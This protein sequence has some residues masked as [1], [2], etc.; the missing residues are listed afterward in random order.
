MIALLKEYVDMFAW[1]PEDMIGIPKLLSIGSTSISVMLL[2]S[3]KSVS[4]K[5]K[6]TK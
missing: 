3:R 5:K 6:G 4:W 2:L 1:K